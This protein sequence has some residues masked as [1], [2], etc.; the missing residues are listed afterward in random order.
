MVGDSFNALV[1]LLHEYQHVVLLLGDDLLDELHRENLEYVDLGHDHAPVDVGL[2]VVR[3]QEVDGETV[4]EEII[5]DVVAVL[6]VLDLWDPVGVLQQAIVD[7]GVES[8][9]SSVEFRHACLVS[10]WRAASHTP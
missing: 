2:V 7:T 3:G 8:R 5:G 1:E 9:I 10:G 4:V 6:G